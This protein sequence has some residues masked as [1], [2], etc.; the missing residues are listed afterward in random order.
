MANTDRPTLKTYFS[1]NRVPTQSDFA[2][3][4]DSMLNQ[5]DD[6]IAKPTD[7]DPLG[8][9]AVGGPKK[10]LNFYENAGESNPAWTLQ[11][12]PRSKQD[13]TSTA[14]LGFSV[15]DGQ[16]TSRLFIDKSTGNVGIGTTDPKFS[17]EVAGTSIKLGLE[18]NGGGQ[19]LIINNKDDNSI[20]LEALSRDGTDHAN[21]LLLTGASGGNVPKLSLN[22]DLTC[23][24]GV[25]SGAANDYMKAQFSLSGGGLVTWEGVGGYLKWSKR[26]IAIS[27]EKPST[28]SHGHF[29]IFFPT[30]ATSVVSH[31]N[32]PRWDANKGILLKG[33][34]A[35]YAIHPV[36]GDENSISFR[37]V[38][39]G[40]DN[41]FAPS[42][43][44]LVAVVNEDDNT[45]KLGTGISVAAGSSYGSAYG[46]SL[47]KGAIIMWSG[48]NNA[49]PLGWALCDGKSGTPNLRD[50]FIVGAGKTYEVGATGGADSVT[51]T[52]DQ[53]PTHN[54]AND[55]YKYLLKVDGQ[56]THTATDAS[57]NEPNIHYVAEMT[58]QGGG[59]SHENRPPYYALCFIMKL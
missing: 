33:W 9:A 46:S 40:N 52:I 29:N 44:L 25:M 56:L 20:C 31:D 54:H 15:S 4:I 45:V 7:S 30:S 49:I 11:L 38:F 18:R 16:G 53:M 28:F 39:Y 32:T 19:L 51:L 41:F 3:L 35:L 24:K 6:G 12:N 5:K 59:K 17:L 27:M 43:W 2:A 48:A 21:E 58:N 8:I 50:R 34:E 42:N 10:L 37:I 47:P 22:A 26:F 1:K 57:A 55:P 23:I 14:R 13:D 36:G